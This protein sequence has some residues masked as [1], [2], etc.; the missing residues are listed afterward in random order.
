MKN[1]TLKNYL[2]LVINS[3]NECCFWLMKTTDEKVQDSRTNTERKNDAPSAQISHK[4]APICTATQWK[5]EW[6]KINRTLSKIA[7]FSHNKLP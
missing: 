3:C 1:T 5:S 7:K 4:L 2:W 6:M